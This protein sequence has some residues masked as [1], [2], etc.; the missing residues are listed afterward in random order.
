M[1]IYTCS[2]YSIE[3]CWHREMSKLPGFCHLRK[4]RPTRLTET[5]V[6]NPASNMKPDNPIVDQPG[7]M[8]GAAIATPLPSAVGSRMAEPGV[9]R[10][11][12]A[13]LLGEVKV[14]LDRTSQ[15]RHW[16]I[17]TRMLCSRVAKP[18]VNSDG[19]VFR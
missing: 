9:R 10:V 5:V 1:P 17:E 4:C 6:D 3:G 14:N 11:G 2:E 7:E 16:N 19:S 13:E 15:N 12:A 18:T 8:S